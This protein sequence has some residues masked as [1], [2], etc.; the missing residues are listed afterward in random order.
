MQAI[1]TTVGYHLEF[2]GKTRW[3]KGTHALD[4]ELEGIRLELTLK[5]FPQM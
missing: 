2:E 4:I 5:P 1:F 3:L